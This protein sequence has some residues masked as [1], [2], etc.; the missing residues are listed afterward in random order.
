MLRVGDG[1]CGGEVMSSRCSAPSTR[2]IMM[3]RRTILAEEELKDGGII[4]TRLLPVRI[5]HRHLV[6]IRQQRLNEWRVRR[7]KRNSRG[8]ASRCH[9]QELT[10]RFLFF[11]GSGT[12]ASPTGGGGS[13][14]GEREG[15]GGSITLS[16][17]WSTV[18]LPFLLTVFHKQ[19][20]FLAHLFSA[21]AAAFAWL[22]AIERGAA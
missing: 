18:T 2:H 5:H 9:C 1:G 16:S 13:V 7:C 10:A 8:S 20:I 22:T 11:F 12:C 4:V 6:Q 15:G 21:A 17:R 19:I 3:R 14:E